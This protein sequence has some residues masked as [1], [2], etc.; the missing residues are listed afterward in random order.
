MTKFTKI[1]VNLADYK[2]ELMEEAHRVGTPVTRPLLLEFPHDERAR[3]ESS[4]FM[5]G[6]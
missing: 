3:V 1:H 5:L 2:R 6:E 4:E